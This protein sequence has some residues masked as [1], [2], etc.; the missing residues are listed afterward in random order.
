[1]WCTWPQEARHADAADKRGEQP[2]VP[3]LKRPIVLIVFNE[4]L[5]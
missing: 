5:R 3:T 4:E 1:M 2:G